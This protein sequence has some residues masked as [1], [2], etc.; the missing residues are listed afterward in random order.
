MMIPFLILLPDTRLGNHRKKGEAEK[1]SFVCSGVSAI[2]KKPSFF[3]LFNNKHS[4][5]VQSSASWQLPVIDYC[6]AWRRCGIIWKCLW[7]RSSRRVFES[8]FVSLYWKKE[9]LSGPSGGWQQLWAQTCFV[10]F[11]FSSLGASGLFY[12]GQILQSVSFALY[13]SASVE[14][15]AETSDERLKSFSI[16]IG[17]TISSVIGTVCANLA[18]GKLCDLFHPGS[19]ILLSLILGSI[20]LL[21][22]LHF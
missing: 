2:G 19:L 18:G 14:C 1:K 3:V 16:S 9:N 12:M 11:V 10:R 21:F 4:L 13:M 7:N 5:L 17:L 8:A 20:N 6:G 15:F 22:F